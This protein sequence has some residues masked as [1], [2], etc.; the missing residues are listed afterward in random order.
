MTV[1]AV[2]MVIAETG[3]K[4]RT[5]LGQGQGWCFQLALGGVLGQVWWA[6]WLHCAKRQVNLSGAGPPSSSCRVLGAGKMTLASAG[7]AYL[8]IH[9]PGLRAPAVRAAEGTAETLL[10]PQ[11][12]QPSMDHYSLHA[13]F[14]SCLACWDTQFTTDF[15][16]AGPDPSRVYQRPRGRSLSYKQ[17]VGI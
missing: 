7:T 1:L 17:C 4:E 13:P 12:A 11:G 16:S 14:A 2:D 8:F 3:W 15:M 9:A 5:W 10:L 6:L